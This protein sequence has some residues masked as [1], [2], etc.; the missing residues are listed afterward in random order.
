VCR[1]RGSRPGAP[2]CFARARA[3]LAHRV[4]SDGPGAAPRLRIT[5]VSAGRSPGTRDHS[6]P[7]LVFAAP[8]P[9]ITEPDAS[10]H[11][12][13]AETRFRRCLDR[14]KYRNVGM[15]SR[16]LAA[17]GSRRMK[18]AMRV[19]RYPSLPCGRRAAGCPPRF[20]SSSS[21]RRKLSRFI[22]SST[23]GLVSAALE[24]SERG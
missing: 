1:H 3:R 10:V 14:N 5:T 17:T 13:G 4:T 12:L 7:C 11:G 8:T 16:F 15:A 20:A 22:F 23:H 6:E 2:R 9:N 19:C 24:C 21:T 18:G